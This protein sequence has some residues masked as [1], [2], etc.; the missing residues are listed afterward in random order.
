MALKLSNNAVS[1]LAASI[2]SG[3]TTLSVQG[4]DAGKFPVLGAGDW[5][6]A[7]IIDPANNMEIVRVTARAGSNLTIVRAQEGTTAK[8]FA[9]GSRIDVRVTAETIGSIVQKSIDDASALNNAIDL[10]MPK[11]GGAFGGAISAKE[12]TVDN[13]AGIDA[14]YYWKQNS[15]Q[16]FSIFAKGDGT[17]LAF[18]KYTDVGGYNGV[19]MQIT[20]STG[21][22]DIL[23]ALAVANELYVRAAVEIGKMDGTAGPALIDFHT[24]ATVRDFNARIMATGDVGNGAAT[25]SIEC[26]PLLNNGHQIL[27]MFHKATAADIA[28]ATENKF[29]D[30]K[31]VKEGIAANVPPSLGV[32]QSWQDVAASRSLGTVYQNTTGRTISV[33]V[34]TTY[35]TSFEVSTNGTTFLQLGYP[36]YDATS[37][38]TSTSMVANGPYEIPPGNYYRVIGGVINSWKEMR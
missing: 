17:S 37:G 9:A 11:S 25:L 24:S 26:G 32:A 35:G 14:V 18:A 12:Y 7:T 21:F 19:A 2:T 8:A 30:A 38:G 27:S 5:H 3:A 4:G 31:A 22:V 23:T 20:R 6:P 1:T 10:R 33:A 36:I 28:A 29:P 16:R 13:G 34:F 15:I